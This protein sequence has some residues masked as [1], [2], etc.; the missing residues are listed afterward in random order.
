MRAGQLG[1]EPAH[2]LALAPLHRP[3][4]RRCPAPPPRTA[5]SAAASSCSRPETSPSSFS[6]SA[7]ARPRP[8]SG[9]LRHAGRDQ[10]TAVDLEDHGAPFPDVVVEP[11]A[12]QR[13]RQHQLGRGASPRQLDAGGGAGRRR[14][15]QLRLAARRTERRRRQ[16]LLTARRP[17]SRAGYA[18]SSATRAASSAPPGR[19]SRSP[20]SPSR[21][22]PSAAFGSA[23]I[24][25]SSA[26][27]RSSETVREVGRAQ[28][29]PGVRLEVESE[30]GRVARRAQ[31]AGRVVLEGALVQDPE[32][33][34]AEVR[35]P[36]VGID[37]LRVSAQRDRHRVEGEVAPREVRP[38]RRRAARPAAL[39]GRGR[40]PRGLWRC[41][42]RA[43]PELGLG[44]GEA[45]VLDHLAAQRA[46]DPRGVALDDHVDVAAPAPEQQVPHRSPDQVGGG[47]PGR[48]AERLELGELPR[49]AHP[50]GPPGF[51]RVQV[52]HRGFPYHDP[53]PGW[54]IRP[55]P[56]AAEGHP[57]PCR[58]A[59]ETPRA[60]R[61]AGGRTAASYGAAV[62]GAR[63][64]GRR[65]G[66]RRLPS[67]E[68][69]R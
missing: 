23:A 68:A 38:E 29:L 62:G 31:G 27:R 42:S 39:P 10:V 16:R 45:L 20:H 63:R 30:A 46:G 34:G 65:G 33:A 13:A 53:F 8:T 47:L 15:G 7:A 56:R 1:L 58:R 11:I 36:A 40:S 14:G 19:S 44:G 2:S 12:A 57:P 3:K 69:P 66:L 22:K 37:Q 51:G 25:R 48:P 50:R 52:V 21:R 6:R 5:A 9:P 28:E 41:R 24:R 32:Q 67:A 54:P 59:R 49:R 26:A 64:A 60:A 61:R 43:P 17:R 55:H 35:P 4:T 18:S